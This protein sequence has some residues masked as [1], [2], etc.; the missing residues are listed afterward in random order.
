MGGT[1][2]GDKKHRYFVKF[3]ILFIWS[4]QFIA[5]GEGIE[6][7]QFE[8]DWGL[9]WL[10]G[11]F[12]DLECGEAIISISFSEE[13]RKSFG[14]CEEPINLHIESHGTWWTYSGRDRYSEIV[15]VIF[16]KSTGYQVRKKLPYGKYLIVDFAY[17][18]EISFVP[19]SPEK[20]E[21]LG[22]YTNQPLIMFEISEEE[23]EVPV[24]MEIK[25]EEKIAHNDL[26]EVEEGDTEKFFK[27]SRIYNAAK[28]KGLNPEGAV[29]FHA[30]PENFGSEYFVVVELEDIQSQKVSEIHYFGKTNDYTYTTEMY[31]G[32]YGI[33]R[34]YYIDREGK[35]L[36]E[37]K[38]V[39]GYK[40]EIL[41]QCNTV[42]VKLG[43]SE[44]QE[45]FPV[46][47]GSEISEEVTIETVVGEEKETFAEIE[48]SEMKITL[49]NKNNLQSNKQM[50]KRRGIYR[51]LAFL[52][53]AGLAGGVGYCR[54]KHKKK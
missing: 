1:E 27:Y 31:P 34:V 13:A 17:M 32:M 7:G 45:I 9:D 36:A 53:L 38:T 30:E 26:D 46:T 8:G 11:D 29:Q 18:G 39:K 28:E 48:T 20:R 16:D 41:P 6:S 37:D 4:F 35:V 5:F 50:Q 22:K 42:V 2:M 24:F 44:I 10:G 51:L 12:S 25:K 15:E 33:H 47:E 43:T 19:L 52:V 54:F 3:L 23:P 49:N 21:E 40:F 14:T